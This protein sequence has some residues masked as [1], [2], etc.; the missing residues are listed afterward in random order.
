MHVYCLSAGSSMSFGVLCVLRTLGYVQWW[1]E[2]IAS[3]RAAGYNHGRNE[4]SFISISAPSHPSQLIA[5]ALEWGSVF[6]G[7]SR[8]VNVWNAVTP[9]YLSSSRLCRVLKCIRLAKKKTGRIGLFWI[10]GRCYGHSWIRKQRSHVGI[11]LRKCGK[12]HAE[13]ER[14]KQVR[15]VQRKPILCAAR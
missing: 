8:G 12:G 1:T 3:S 5:G 10:T 13:R 6:A 14:S 7:F 4:S 2:S 11:V 15:D 9:G